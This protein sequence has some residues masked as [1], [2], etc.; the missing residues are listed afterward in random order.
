[1]YGWSRQ[2]P[3]S[4][5]RP[6]A[7]PHAPNYGPRRHRTEV[8]AVGALRPVIAQQDQ[9]S[10]ALHGRDSLDRHTA[11]HRAH[12]CQDHLTGPRAAQE[13]G[14][15]V[16]Q[17]AIAVAKNGFHARTGDAHPLCHTCRQH[18][19]GTHHKAHHQP[20]RAH[21]PL[22]VPHGFAVA[23]RDLYSTGTAMAGPTI[24]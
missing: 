16:D 22:L 4:L 6:V 18:R 24:T 15:P 17:H 10:A 2:A 21:Q 3:T 14:Q 9:V 8:A 12:P 11:G 7:I 23:G 20:A 13:I 1:V 5:W 19:A